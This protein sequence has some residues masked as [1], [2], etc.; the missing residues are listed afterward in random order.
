MEIA[1][2]TIHNN[3]RGIGTTDFDG[4]MFTIANNTIY[5]NT[6]TSAVTGG[7]IGF[8]NMVST[9]NAVI[10]GNTIYGNT[11]TATD[12]VGE[13]RARSASG[14]I[15]LS[16]NYI[17]SNMGAV[18]GIGITVSN[19]TFSLVNNQV[20]NNIGSSS[21]TDL[22]NVGGIGFNSTDLPPYVVPTVMLVF[23]S[24]SSFCGIVGNS[25]E[26]STKSTKNF[27]KLGF[28]KLK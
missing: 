11:D 23:Y 18:G 1:Y 22:M 24:S 4:T 12:G 21:D 7:G 16:N 6:G 14:S 20:M 26:L 2:N 3:K 28:A 15:S 27:K 9:G 5:S 8:S 19:G 25:P 13:I 17:S 10:K